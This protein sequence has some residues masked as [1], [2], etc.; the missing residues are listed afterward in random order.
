ME[1]GGKKIPRVFLFSI[2]ENGDIETQQMAE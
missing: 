1:G 2:L